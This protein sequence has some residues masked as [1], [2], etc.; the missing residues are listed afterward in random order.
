[1]RYIRHYL[2]GNYTISQD[3]SV[4]LSSSKVLKTSSGAFGTYTTP[5][6][7]PGF[8]AHRYVWLLYAQPAPFN[9]AG[10]ESIGLVPAE[11]NSFN[12][13]PQS[14]SRAF[15]TLVINIADRDTPWRQKL[16]SFLSKAALGAPVGGSYYIMDPQ[17][18]G[19]GSSGGN[20]STAG[21]GAAGAHTASM[22]TL[23]IAFLSCL[24]AALML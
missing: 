1:M 16:T 21:K 7:P 9:T 12:V 15:V 10:F 18:E 20:G 5:N 23:G 19:S 6:P 24:C 14:F 22:A 13:S 11:R 2:A 3:A 4:L 8:G 17:P